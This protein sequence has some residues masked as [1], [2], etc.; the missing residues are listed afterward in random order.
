MNCNKEECCSLSVIFKPQKLNVEIANPIINVEI[1][2]PIIKEYINVE[3]YMGNYTVTPTEEIQVLSTCT[4]QMT[5]DLIV[6]PIPLNYGRI[7]H[8]GRIIIIQ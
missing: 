4:K 2:N 3:P 1:A 6:E 8:N 5:K 7:T